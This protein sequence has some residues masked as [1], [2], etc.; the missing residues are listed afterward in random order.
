MN[1]VFEAIGTHWD[2]QTD[3][4]LSSEISKL[5]AARIEIFDKTYSRFRDDSLMTKM[6]RHAGRYELPD[7]VGRMMEL[8]EKMYHLTGGAVTPLIGQVM[9]DAG[10]DAEYSLQSKPLSQP[11]KWEETI[12]FSSPVIDMKQPALLDFG[13]AGKGHLVDIIG[14]LLETH[15]IQNYLIDA[16]GDIRSRSTSVQDSRIGLEHPDNPEQVIGVAAL[17]NQSLCGSAGN[18]RQWENFNH[19]ISPHTLKSPE[20]IKAV[21]TTA[22]TTMLADGM[23]TCLFFARPDVLLPAFK[24]EYVIVYA[25]NSA[26]ISPNFP[27]ELYT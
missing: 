25:D 18:R 27:G 6:S 21:W 3:I 10:Y 11:P 4:K 13:A 5:I 14:E 1:L 7:D 19:M 12:D 23:S 26:I 24:F 22:E 17:N 2:I 16:G 9:S 15:G 20:N 8:Y